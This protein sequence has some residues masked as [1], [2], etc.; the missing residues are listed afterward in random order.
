MHYDHPAA[1][2]RHGATLCKTCEGT[3][4]VD[5]SIGPPWAAEVIRECRDCRGQGIHTD[6][7]KTYRCIARRLVSGGKHET[8]SLNLPTLQCPPHPRNGTR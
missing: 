3:G 4:Q 5:V 2:L 8:K 6:E 1:L 7:L